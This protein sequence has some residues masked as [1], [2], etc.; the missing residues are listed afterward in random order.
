LTTGILLCVTIFA[1]QVIVSGLWLN[2]FKRGP[3]E[4]VWRFFTYG[5]RG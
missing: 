1:I 4:A 5:K 3:M 2:R